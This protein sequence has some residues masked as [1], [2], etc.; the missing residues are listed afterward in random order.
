MRQA[1]EEINAI[2]VSPNV[3]MLMKAY[4]KS[5]LMN[6]G[7]G[8]FAERKQLLPGLMPALS[9]VYGR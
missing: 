3:A 6:K 5:G 2:G 1:F 8:A 4:S 7:E 9:V